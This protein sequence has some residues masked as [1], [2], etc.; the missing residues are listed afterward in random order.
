MDRPPP[1]TSPSQAGD[2]RHLRSEPRDSMFLLASVRRAGGPDVPVKVR[3]LSQ[4]GLMA[5]CPSGFVRGEE[6]QVELRGIGTVGG[7]IAWTASGRIGIQFDYA[8]DHRRARVPVGAGPKPL[9]AHHDASTW[10]PA[11]R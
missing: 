6:I 1:P 4:G 7:K 11:V 10:R 5:D 2:V 8:I 9:I 3:N